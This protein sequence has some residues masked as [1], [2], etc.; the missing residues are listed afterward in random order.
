[1]NTH[2]KGNK[3]EA[4]LEKIKTYMAYRLTNE[5]IIANLKEGNCEISERTLRRFKVEIKRKAG[6]SLDQIILN[7]IVKESAEDVFAIKE[8][9]KQAWQVCNTSKIGNEKIKALSFVRNLILD[10]NKLYN[11]T[12]RWLKQMQLNKNYTTTIDE[13][14][15]VIINRLTDNNKFARSKLDE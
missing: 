12:P 13:Y 9:Q 6:I 10:K 5:E 15:N 11:Q 2:L 3:R 7:E 8:M 14:G 4:V 1:M